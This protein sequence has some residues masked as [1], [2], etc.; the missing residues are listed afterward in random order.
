[1]TVNRRFAE[2]SP[3]F[4]P[5][6]LSRFF[7]DPRINYGYIK[8]YV[9][10]CV[11]WAGSAVTLIIMLLRVYYRNVFLVEG[12]F[13]FGHVCAAICAYDFLRE[14]HVPFGCAPRSCIISLFSRSFFFCVPSSPRHFLENLCKQTPLF[15]TE[16][17]SV[18]EERKTRA[19][20][21][22]YAVSAWLPRLRKKGQGGAE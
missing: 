9:E 1:M 15:P 5:I 4:R 3:K 22:K 8:C 10:L 19:Y 2:N 7:E 17:S 6:L 20:L 18:E 11:I 14:N 21:S 12:R 16:R 13:V